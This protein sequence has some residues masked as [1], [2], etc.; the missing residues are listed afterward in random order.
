MSSFWQKQLKKSQALNKSGTVIGQTK[1]GKPV[2]KGKDHHPEYS[3]LDHM[4]AIKI[5]KD[6]RMKEKSARRN[7]LSAPLMSGHKASAFK[8]ADPYARQNTAIKGVSDR[9]IEARRGDTR[10]KGTNAH[11]Y[12]RVSSPEEHKATAKKYFRSILD[13]VRSMP[14][15]N[16]PKSEKK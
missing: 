6:H 4:E 11:G 13:K 7:D 8:K 16:L 5:N 10:I 12:S 15:P 2:H 9:G 3:Q 14:K 1:S